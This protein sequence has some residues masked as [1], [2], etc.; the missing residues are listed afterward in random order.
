MNK[1]PVEPAGLVREALEELRAGQA[2]RRVEVALGRLPLCQADPRLL[3][4]VFVN[5]LSNAFKYTRREEVALIEIGSQS[6]S[7]QEVYYVRDNG[8]GFDMGR[9][10]KLF[11][12]F[13]RLH[14]AADFEGAGVGLA[15]VQRI[16]HR[17]GG[18]VWADAEVG[19]G[20]T[21][22]FTLP[23]G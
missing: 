15:N 2:G 5:L 12:V 17:H 20:A 18:R 8:V 23:P 9:A 21:F 6:L 14:S 7:G 13:Q 1:E 4:Q 10:A 11:G 3:K 16:I 22:Y 19:Q